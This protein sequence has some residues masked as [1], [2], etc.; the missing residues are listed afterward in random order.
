LLNRLRLRIEPRSISANS[1][2]KSLLAMLGL[3]GRREDGIMLCIGVRGQSWTSPRKVEQTR[4]RAV[5]YAPQ[6]A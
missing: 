5:G 6:Q 4:W 1:F 3:R 2:L